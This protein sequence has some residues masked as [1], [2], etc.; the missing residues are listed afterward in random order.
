[1]LLDV[2]IDVSGNV[3]DFL[4][5]LY[6]QFAIHVLRNIALI[7]MISSHYTINVFLYNFLFMF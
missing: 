4:Y 6:K 7:V 3:T 1:M 5:R 2:I